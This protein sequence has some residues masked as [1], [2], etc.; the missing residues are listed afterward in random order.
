[1]EESEMKVQTQKNIFHA[2]DA[3]DVETISLA[4]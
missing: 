2:E 1:M 3:V 4:V